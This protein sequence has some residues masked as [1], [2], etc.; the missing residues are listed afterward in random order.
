M[1]RKKILPTYVQSLYRSP[2]QW[3]RPGTGLRQ[4]GRGPPRIESWARRRLPGF[5]EKQ[6][7][8]RRDEVIARNAQR[9]SQTPILPD[10]QSV[11][12]AA[13]C[14]SP[15][16]RRTDF[17]SVR[18][19][20]AS[21][22]LLTTLSATCRERSGSACG[23]EGRACGGEGRACGGEG[24]KVGGEGGQSLT[25]NPSREG[26]GLQAAEVIDWHWLQTAA[27]DQQRAALAAIGVGGLA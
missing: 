9:L 12:M 10:G 1:V 25:S 24:R 11:T 3:L 16:D 2:R 19:A 5:F 4:A 21:V 14:A 7:D 18:V 13:Y 26:V 8:P 22:R 27:M 23:G 6:R 15:D 17:Q 20:G